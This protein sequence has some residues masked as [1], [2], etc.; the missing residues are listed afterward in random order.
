MN[1]AEAGPSKIAAGYNPRLAGT[2]VAQ[3]DRAV[4]TPAYTTTAEG[5]NTLSYGY[6]QLN[7]PYSESQ[8]LTIHNTER[9]VADVRPDDGVHRQTPW[10]A[11][12]TFSASPVV[13]SRQ[14]DR[15]PWT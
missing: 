3:A 5:R 4:S 10:G 12:V 9:R 11:D 7:G 15:Q 1:T 6:E 8:P 14:A 13:R 2:G